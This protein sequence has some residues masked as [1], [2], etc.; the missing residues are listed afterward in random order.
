MLKETFLAKYIS[1][2]EVSKLIYSYIKN[3][4]EAY[5]TTSIL[6]LLI[7]VIDAILVFIY[8]SWW[9][10]VIISVLLLWIYQVLIFRKMYNI[11]KRL[12]KFLSRGEVVNIDNS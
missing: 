4:N 11:L 9:L 7:V 6:Y 5:K 1:D 10:A 8:I 12:D 3:S 2:Q